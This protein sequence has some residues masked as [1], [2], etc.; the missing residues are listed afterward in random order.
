M[1]QYMKRLF[2]I[3]LAL[4]IAGAFSSTAFAHE[5]MRHNGD[6]FFKK[7][8]LTA[9]QKEK[10]QSLREQHEKT[11]IDLKAELGKAMIDKRE[12][13]RKGNI[14]RKSFLDADDKVLAVQN[15]IH[16]AMANH[17]MDVY[18]LLTTE[19]KD[20]VTKIADF[21]FDHPKM[22]RHGRFGFNNQKGD[23][24]QDHPGMNKRHGD[25]DHQK[26]DKDGASSPKSE[27]K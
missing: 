7:L 26:K 21:F 24:W 13:V 8:N 25:A 17:K 6:A 18:A 19:Q 3:A 14:D 20:K 22:M 4:L 10:I 5:G 23:A 11:M 12:I 2:N 16:T 27:S 1:E 9:E 15:K